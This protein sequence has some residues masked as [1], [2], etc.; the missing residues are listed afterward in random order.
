ML[1]G[2]SLNYPGFHGWFWRKLFW[3]F[4]NGRRTF[5]LA[6][7]RDKIAGLAILKNEI[8]ESKICTLFVDK[9]YRRA[10]VG[11]MLLDT[12][13]QVLSA[14]NGALPFITVPERRIDSLGPLLESRGFVLTDVR[15]GHYLPNMNE[16][17]FNGYF[18]GCPPCLFQ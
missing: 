8:R 16:Y 12:S 4:L 3:G 10:E 7:H 18:E 13:I 17:L 9:R 11:S 1:L 14:Q 6:M 15:F 2:L 5:L